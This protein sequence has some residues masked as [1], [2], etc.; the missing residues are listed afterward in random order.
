MGLKVAPRPR[1]LLDVDEWSDAD[2][3]QVLSSASGYRNAPQSDTLRDRHVALLFAEPSTRTR[4]SFQIAA[5]N[6]GAQTALF[7]PCPNEKHVPFPFRSIGYPRVA[8]YT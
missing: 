5:H 7:S 1:H 4:L 6:M 8:L 2:I 3:E